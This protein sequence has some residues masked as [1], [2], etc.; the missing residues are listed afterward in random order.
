MIYATSLLE[1]QLSKAEMDKQKIADEA[2]RRFTVM[3]TEL[4]ARLEDARDS[5]VKQV[6]LVE[7]LK[8]KVKE[9]RDGFEKTGKRLTE[10]EHAAKQM[11]IRYN[12]TNEVLKTLEE[13]LRITEV[14]PFMCAYTVKSR[15]NL[16]FSLL[17]LK[18]RLHDKSRLFKV[19]FHFDDKIS[20]L[21]SRLYIKSRFIKSR[22]YCI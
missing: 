11:E 14:S 2:Y 17:F 6:D 22:L 1:G 19:K 8:D 20:F 5:Q 3:K 18:S 13:R 21:K 10:A 7:R 4:E 9:Y 12:D 16:Q 15:F